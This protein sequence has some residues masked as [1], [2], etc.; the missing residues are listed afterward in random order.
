MNVMEELACPLTRMNI[1]LELQELLDS[2]SDHDKSAR[3]GSLFDERLFSGNPDIT[4]NVIFRQYRQLSAEVKF[5]LSLLLIDV[6][7]FGW[8]AA[9]AGSGVPDDSVRRLIWNLVQI[10]TANE[11][12]IRI[13]D[14]AFLFF[15]PETDAAARTKMADHIIR[16]TDQ[17]RLSEDSPLS[18][19]IGQDTLATRLDDFLTAL[20]HVAEECIQQRFLTEGTIR[21][22]LIQAL[23]VPVFR[24]R[25]DYR[26][27]V[28]R[29]RDLADGFARHLGLN[30]KDT[31][32]L[33]L[34]CLVHDIGMLTVPLDVIGK[35]GPL[36][37]EESLLM[38]EHPV[39][40]QS[41]IL[42]IPELVFLHELVVS[43]HERWDG[44]GYPDGL[45]GFD[46]PRICRIFGIL[47][48]FDVLTHKRSYGP[49]MATGEA[50][51]FIEGESGGAF[52]PVLV[53]EFLAHAAGW[54]PPPGQ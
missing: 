54:E 13:G 5:P 2:L 30:Q 36:T 1:S 6:Q 28:W 27:H 48:V 16:I 29:T 33:K 49:P 44:G 23:M 46:I 37:E 7:G 43:H 18:V 10:S 52:D 41:M 9:I 32:A 19:A 17:G 12:L 38:R 31:T 24:L 35:A 4:D 34:L 26:S 3:M 40:G 51:E 39:E 25:E 53:R 47:D 42:E 8:N 15:L 22:S 21:Y 50:L 20:N 11:T 45:K 14:H